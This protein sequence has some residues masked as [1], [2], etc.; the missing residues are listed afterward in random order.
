A[1]SDDLRRFFPRAKP[2]FFGLYLVGHGLYTWG[3]N[4]AE[5][6]RHMEVWEYLFEV[7]L[8]K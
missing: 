7:I 2:P 6:K 3:E 5:A 8:K 1:L 4:T